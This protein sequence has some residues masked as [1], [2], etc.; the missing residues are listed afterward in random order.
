MR[1]EAIVCER[2]DVKSE[3]L[4]ERKEG[5]EKEEVSFVRSFVFDALAPRF[6]KV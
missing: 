5:K 4:H 3:D 1:E 6:E 2:E